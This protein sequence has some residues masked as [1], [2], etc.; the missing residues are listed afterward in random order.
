M[1]DKLDDREVF[2]RRAAILPVEGTEQIEGPFL[3]C[4]QF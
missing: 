4:I 1:V 2:S 3:L